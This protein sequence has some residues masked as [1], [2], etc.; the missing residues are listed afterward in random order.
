[1]IGI[2]LHESGPSRTLEWIRRADELGVPSV[3]LTSGSV[4][5][6]SI[7]SAAAATTRRI[8]L[9][10]AVVPTWLRHPLLLAQQAATIADLARG[11]LVLGVGPS[12]RP[13]MEGVYGVDFRK[14]LQQTREYVAVLRQASRQGKVEFDG[15]F[16]HVHAPAAP[17]LE[18]PIMISALQPGSFRLA[19]EIADGAIAWVC[20]AAYLATKARTALEEGE[21]K[22]PEGK[23]A[24]PLLIAHTFLCVGDDEDAIRADA[25]Q[26]L[27]LYPRLPFYARMLAEAGDDEA[28]SGVVSD[29]MIDSVVVYGGVEA[30]A[31]KLRRFK[32]EAGADEVIASLMAAGPDRDG[33][34]EAG[35]RAVLAARS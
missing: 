2:A 20:P 13:M 24:R 27:A 22:R 14:P 7:L 19:G 3:W 12:H 26:R 15:Q 25:R 28:A 33:G 18:A 30:C 16:F 35:L 21:G 32:E 6:M 31:E 4:E 34:L 1:M 23:T 29:R 10:T 11:R 9:G 8:R 17:T 5:Q